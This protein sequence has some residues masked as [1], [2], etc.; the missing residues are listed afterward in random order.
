MDHH[1]YCLDAQTG[2]VIWDFE[3][4]GALAAQPSPDDG[5][6][7]QGALDGR[8]YA[9]QADSGQKASSFDFQADNWIWSEALVADGRLYVTSLDGNLYGLDAATGQ[10]LPGYPY[11]V[12]ATDYIRAAPAQVGGLI[13]IATANGQVVAVNGESGQVQ[14]TWT[15]G[16]LGVGILT[17]PVI[18]GERIYVILA[19]GQ[20]QT[21][22]L[23]KGLLAPSWTFSP[24]AA[25]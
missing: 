14:G 15:S 13:I 24:P 20:V 10:A 7:Y 18:S 3:A 19:N 22:E 4:G 21:F 25:K 9:I 5:T 16:T 6:L 2:Q 1:L 23:V 11:K 8:V 17:T 12:A